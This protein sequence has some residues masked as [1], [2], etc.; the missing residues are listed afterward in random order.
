M[1]KAQTNIELI[2][3]FA[4]IVAFILIVGLVSLAVAHSAAD[5]SANVTGETYPMGIAELQANLL[6]SVPR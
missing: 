6:K 5:A 4:M 2:L 1:C 3:F